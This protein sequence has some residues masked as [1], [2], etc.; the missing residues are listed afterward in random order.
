[1]ISTGRKVYERFPLQDFQS[2]RIESIVVSDN[3][4]RIFVGTADGT[5]TAVQC[6]TSNISGPGKHII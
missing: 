4:Q 5:L 6:R 1:M 3:G 2:S